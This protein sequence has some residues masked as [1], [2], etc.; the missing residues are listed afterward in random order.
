VLSFRSGWSKPHYIYFLLAGFAILTVCVG[1]FITRSIMSTYTASVAANASWNERLLAYSH[2]GKLAEAVDAPGNDV[3]DSR[4]PIAE[5]R[6]MRIALHVFN[7]TLEELRAELDANL[8][9]DRAAPLVSRL[10]AVETGMQALTAE[11]ELTFSHF[12]A[13]RLSAAG[14]QM[15]T[16]DRKYAVVSAGL[17][18]LRN[19][20]ARIQQ[21]NFEEQMAAAARMQKYEYLVGLLVLLM[22]AAAT[23]YGLHLAKRI[24]SYSTR[25]Q[26]VFKHELEAHEESRKS[27]A[28]ELH[29]EV[30]QM[31]ASLKM[32][33]ELLR[34][35]AHAGR[36]TRVED[37][38]TIVEGA[39]DRLRDMVRDLTPHGMEEL[40]LAPVLAVHLRDWTAGSG[41]RV[42]F[43]E[44]MLEVR[45]PPGIETAA[46]RI[47]KELVRNAVRHARA[48]S[49]ALELRQID[50]E[51][52]LRVAD[53]GVGFDVASA[54]KHGSG[55]RLGLMSVEQRVALLGG[56]LQIASQPGGG[57]VARVFLPTTDTAAGTLSGP[58][59]LAA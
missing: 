26:V 6:R 57:T 29:E 44:S 45:P 18:E 5:E 32:H 3:F 21:G 34:L 33:L 7:Q 19:A 37:I 22:V 10:D 35:E 43:A 41:L 11:A 16:M 59:E 38:N 46:Y 36:Y 50:T 12:Q 54:T 8:A 48:S 47:A 2:L 31:L 15:A 28:R 55:K 17:A 23:L 24:N 30:A 4:D 9:P 40:G 58:G 20:V 27:L 56:K 1:L 42:H 52:H 39:L 51:L 49:L 53:D 14:G 25:T 13:G